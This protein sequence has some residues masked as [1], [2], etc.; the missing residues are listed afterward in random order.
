MSTHSENCI[1]AKIF[2]PTEVRPTGDK[3]DLHN[4]YIFMM[5]LLLRPNTQTAIDLKLN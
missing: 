1:I 2:F 5:I 3:K 4:L